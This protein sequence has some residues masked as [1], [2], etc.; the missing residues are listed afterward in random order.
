M[1]TSPYLM[2]A[3]LLTLALPTLGA[4]GD[5]PMWRRDSALTGYQPT[6][7]AMAKEPRVLARLFLGASPGTATL[8][9]LLGSGRDSEVLVLA[10]ARLA[11]YGADGERLWE[12]RPQ[13]YVLDHVEWVEDLD[14]DGRNEVVALAGRMGG[15]RQAYLILDG[16]SGERRAAIDFI[17][18]D[19]GWKGLCG[20]YLSDAKGKQIFL[21]TSMRQAAGDAPPELTPPGSPHL[22][23]P[24]ANGEFSLWAYDGQDVHRRWT[25]TPKEYYV[26]YPAVLV[27]DLTG[28][29]RLRAVVDSW[30]HVWN[31]D[32]A[33]GEIASH[34]TWDPGGA[35]GRHYGFTRLLDVDGDGKLDFVNL[36]LTKHIDVLRNDGGKLVHAWTHAWPDTVTTE[37]RLLRW[38]GEPIVDLDCEGRPE[39]VAALFD[40]QADRRWHLKVYEAANGDAAGRDPRRGAAGDLPAV[41]QGGRFGPAV[42]PDPFPPGRS[43]GVLR[44]PAG[45]GHPSRV[46]STREG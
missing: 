38:P 3:L 8:A 37:V 1:K 25:R 18:G 2:A 29:G 16:R 22:A 30:C 31:I 23:R 33:T 19:F 10:G 5:W 24:V 28:T 43:S 9:D 14:G 27:G 46:C 32:L 6:P 15:T 12:S 11:A 36:A 39:V 40:G 4:D 34:T 35:N 17:T 42:R 26:E 45:A 41:G 44:G 21:V 7:G 20:A 13:G